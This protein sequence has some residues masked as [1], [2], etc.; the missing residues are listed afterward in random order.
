MNKKTFAWGTFFISVVMLSLSGYFYFF[1]GKEMYRSES[2]KFSSSPRKITQ[3]FKL[4][5]EDDPYKMYMDIKFELKNEP[6]RGDIQMFNY[7]ATLSDMSGNSI[8]HK[9]ATYSHHVDTTDDDE[10]PTGVK[11]DTITLFTVDEVKSGDYTFTLILTPLDDVPD[12]AALD[13]FSLFMK[14][15]VALVPAWAPIAGLILL[16]ISI[17]LFAIDRKNIPVTG[18]ES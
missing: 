8:A 4:D 14:K 5:E 3:A 10:S 9:S 12:Y 13:T 2:E 1:S 16:G 7:E 18:E 11:Y 6:D 15:N 17:V